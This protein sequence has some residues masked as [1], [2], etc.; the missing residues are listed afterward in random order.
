MLSL[1][2]ASAF[3]EDTELLSDIGRVVAIWGAINNMLRAVASSELNC[4]EQQADLILNRFSGESAKISFIVDLI[5][6]R[7]DHERFSD[8]TTVLQS[9]LGLTSARNIIVHGGPVKSLVRGI[10]YEPRL[11]NFRTDAPHKRSVAAKPYVTGHLREVRRLAGQLFDT[12]YAQQIMI[13]DEE[14]RS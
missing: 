11:V 12:A 13:L 6:A 4:S 3:E 1:D 2:F 7:P 8:A 10:G 14:Q 9:L 5:A